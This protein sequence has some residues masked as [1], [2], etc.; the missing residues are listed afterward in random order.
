[1]ARRRPRARGAR[2]PSGSPA[3]GA[4]AGLT[5]ALLRPSLV[6]SGRRPASSDPRSSQPACIGGLSTSKP[7]HALLVP[8]IPP[9]VLL[10]GAVIG[11]AG[12]RPGEA[13]VP[14][15]EQAGGG[16]RQQRHTVIGP[17]VGP[18]TGAH[19]HSAAASR[20]AR[21]STR[22]LAALLLAA[23]VCTRATNPH[24]VRTVLRQPHRERRQ[25]D[26]SGG[27]PPHT[28]EEAGSCYCDPDTV[29][30]AAGDT[31]VP[32]GC[33]PYA[34]VEDGS[35]PP[36]CTCN[37]FYSLNEDGDGCVL[38]CA[39]D[40]HAD[41]WD[42]NS[43]CSCDEGFVI[44]D[45]GNGCERCPHGSHP[46]TDPAA[47]KNDGP[48]CA[49]DA[50]HVRSCG[51]VG[52]SSSSSCV[53]TRDA[54]LHG[55]DVSAAIDFTGGYSNPTYCEWEIRC[56]AD[57]EV[58]V[59]QFESFETRMYLDQLL[60]FSG[61]S[62]NASEPKVLVAQYSGTR[63]GCDDCDWSVVDRPLGQPFS[64]RGAHVMRLSFVADK[65]GWGG[66]DGFAVDYRCAS[67]SG[68]G[69][70]DTNAPNFSP[71]SEV[72]DGSC[73]YRDHEVLVSAFVVHPSHV[74]PWHTWGWFEPTDPC[75]S[76]SGAVKEW[77]GI[78][79]RDGRVF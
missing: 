16:S 18:P 32:T 15:G 76:N 40:T 33:P 70:T 42:H 3:S 49:C 72:D 62:T 43:Y 26:D 23:F 37:E 12:S 55:G 2:R 56:D 59:L 9:R 44:S 21:R 4:A 14:A 1:M 58:V 10:R 73:A 45:D 34:H 28:R 54:S 39:E 27:C 8:P 64:R 41:G 20:M 5:Q 48:K 51:E 79:C 71:T 36:A 35:D 53:S 68:L 47:A 69:C 63:G 67:A 65:S 57:S 7:H 52:S 25:L 60:I 77:F 75:G 30:N 50:E 13:A 66:Y 6:Q 74:S 11:P 29:L 38:N 31:C 61:G 46:N 22:A 78:T 24:L 19:T 17:V